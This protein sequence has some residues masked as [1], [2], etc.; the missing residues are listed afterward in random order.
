MDKVKI[1]MAAL[2][3]YH[4]WVLLGV[5]LVVSLT[6]WAMATGTIAKQFQQRKQKLDGDSQKLRGIQN[7]A[8]HPNEEVVKR[9]RAVTGSLSDKV[10]DAWAKLFTQQQK[11]NPWPVNLG[12]EF[13]KVM[14]QLAPDE[15]IPE[16]YRQL[17]QT[18]ILK[19]LAR[20][21]DEVGTL[22]RIEPTGAA[23]KPS[24]APETEE[25]RKSAEYTGIVAWDDKDRNRIESSFVWPTVPTSV[26]VRLAQEDLWVYNA[27]LQIV[28]NTN[29]LATNAYNASIRQIDA[30]AIGREAG[31][32]WGKFQGAA[33]PSGDA[34]SDSGQPQ[35]AEGPVTGDDAIARQLKDNRYVDQNQRPLRASQP[36]PFAEFKMMP[37][38]MSL[39]VQQGSIP[40]L[41][42]HCANSNMPVEV[43]VLRI[44]PGAGSTASSSASRDSGR[45]DSRGGKSGAAIS[46]VDERSRLY[47]PVEILGIIYIYNPPERSKVQGTEGQP[48]EGAP[49]TETA[50]APVAEANKPEAETENPNP[51]AENPN[52]PAENPNP[53]AENPNPPAENPSPTADNPSPPS[54]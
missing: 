39:V 10:F 25:G 21:R 1:Y 8:D 33:K 41:L 30:L 31:T 35:Q 9:V 49:A 42:V 48:G 34:P 23:A 40:E 47:V 28:K 46:G 13:A 14:E 38:Y 17:Y 15:E 20:L 44:R 51:P 26:Q 36:Q 24:Q 12:E 32:A 6:C 2:I 27:L 54:T 3:K 50:E 4:F 45:D 43:K 22:R 16:N 7:E 53:P 37:V 11:N 29:A 52:P 18:F 5:A 19:D